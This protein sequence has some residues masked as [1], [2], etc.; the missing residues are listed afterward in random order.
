MSQKK[1]LLFRISIAF[2]IILIAI[3]AWEI[4]N[5][6]FVKEQ[7]LLTEVQYNLV[8]LEGVIA[9]QSE[10]NWPEPNL[11]TTK[12]GDVLNGI[13]LGKTTGEQLGI[14]SENDE[15]I[16]STLYTKLSRYPNDELYSFIDVSEEGKKNF[17]ELREVLREAG[18]GLN[19]SISAS[20]DSFMKQAKEIG[21]KA[22][23]PID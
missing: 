1:K 7:V 17:E 13:L 6:Y 22:N 2:N 10:K 18:L 19:I 20:M 3:V 21:E 11:V 14:L 15:I 9:N 5:L 16:L 8:E 23:P 4:V 12:L